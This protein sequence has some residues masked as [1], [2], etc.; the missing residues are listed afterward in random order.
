MKF[1]KRLLKEKNEILK[2]IFVELEENRKEN[3]EKD[4]QINNLMKEMIKL[5]SKIGTREYKL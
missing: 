5:S 3:L 1:L 2:N 4:K